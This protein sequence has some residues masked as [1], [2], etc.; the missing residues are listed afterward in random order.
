MNVATI[1]VCNIIVDK[2]WLMRYV[3]MFMN[4]AIGDVSLNI[5]IKN[6]NMAIAVNV[7][8]T[9]S[10]SSSPKLLLWRKNTIINEIHNIK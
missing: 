2:G 6:M 1:K 4:F 9:G 5:N 8:L 10:P 3:I 7:A